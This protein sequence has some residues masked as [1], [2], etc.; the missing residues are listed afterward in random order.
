MVITSPMPVALRI[1][2]ELLA[3]HLEQ[4][5]VSVIVSEHVDFT[6]G[7]AVR[8]LDGTDLVAPEPMLGRLELIKPR[9]Q[10]VRVSAPD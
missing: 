3:K 4:D 1:V 8:C 9:R 6:K 10:I 7:G 2:V 5:D